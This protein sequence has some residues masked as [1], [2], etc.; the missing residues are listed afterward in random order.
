MVG[1]E[2]AVSEV[3]PKVDSPGRIFLAVFAQ[4]LPPEEPRLSGW[5]WLAQKDFGTPL[6]T[7][8]GYSSCRIVSARYPSMCSVLRTNDVR[9]AS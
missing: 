6:I 2:C 7:N 5:L 3:T 4:I 8:Q 1:Y 9:T